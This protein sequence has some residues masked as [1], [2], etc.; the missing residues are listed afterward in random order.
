MDPQ[1]LLW[2]TRKLAAHLR[3]VSTSIHT[4]P[5]P[6][7]QPPKKGE[8][9]LTPVLCHALPCPGS[10][11]SHAMC[12][13]CLRYHLSCRYGQFDMSGFP[14]PNAL[15]YRQHWLQDLYDVPTASN[16]APRAEA[17]S[18]KPTV[19]PPATPATSGTGT[20]TLAL[21][22]DVPSAATCTG[23]KVVLDG[24]D[25]ALLRIAVVGAEGNPLLTQRTDVNVSV[26]VVSGPGRL[27][28]TFVY[29]LLRTAT[30]SLRHPM[31]WQ[32]RSLRRSRLIGATQTEFT[33]HV[34]CRGL[35]LL[36]FFFCAI[37]MLERCKETAANFPSP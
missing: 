8:G 21:T 32:H 25:V 11:T 5:N 19:H 1:R 26:V 2:R 31:V 23:D 37:N 30:L 7:P 4:N 16:L 14:K 18:A 33:R 12:L 22:V 15:W 24:R 29:I 27:I 17:T 36:F 9:L 3:F 35:A 10:L 28:G 20:G 13:Q 34:S 6:T